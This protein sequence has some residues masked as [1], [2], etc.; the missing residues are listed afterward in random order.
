MLLHT[1][2]LLTNTKNNEK[3]AAHYFK[4]PSVWTYIAIGIAVG[5]YCF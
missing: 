5:V 1:L 4:H 2:L 3:V